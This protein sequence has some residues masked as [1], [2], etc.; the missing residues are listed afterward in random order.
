MDKLTRHLAV[1]PRRLHAAPPV[2]SIGHVRKEGRVTYAFD[3]LNFS[4]VLA[5]RGDYV[6]AGRTHRLEAPA[7]FVQ[8][9]DEPMDYGPDAGGWEELFLLYTPE[10]LPAWRASACFDPARPVWRVAAPYF[11]DAVE[12]LLAL[13]RSPR[14]ARHADRIDLACQRLVVESL[15]E[16]P[17]TTG[18][19]ARD[20]VRRIRGQIEADFRRDHD[21]DA[22]ACRH[23]LSPTHFR[24]LWKE[25]VGTPPARHQAHLRLRQACRELVETDRP[26]GA[27]AADLGFT[28]QLY[29]ARRFRRFTGL[30]ATAYRR[31]HAQVFR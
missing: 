15:L 19:P 20:A 14:M 13:L 17:E 11:R 12:D 30:S 16:A 29:F 25:L 31:R 28:D 23:D 22:L 18:S 2:Q 27:I 6:Q 7:A 10:H 1:L 3:T 21:F 8:W 5:G 4:F 9:P 26:I 24:R